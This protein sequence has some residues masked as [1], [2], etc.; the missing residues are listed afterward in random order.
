MSHLAYSAHKLPAHK[1]SAHK[2]SALKYSAL[3]TVAVVALAACSGPTPAPS[4]SP[5][6]DGTP[7]PSAPG[8]LTVV[9]HESFALPEELLAR[10]ADQTGLEVTYITPGEGTSLVNQLIL[11]KDSPLGDVVYGIDNGFAARAVDEGVLT[12]WTSP[13]STVESAF[14]GL[15]PIN[16]GDVC[17]N[18]DLTWFDEK[19]LALPETFEDLTDEAYRDLLVV[20]NPATSSPGMAMLA[21]TV[22]TF[23]EDGWLDYWQRL[24]DNG[25]RIAAGWTEAYYTDFS[26]GESEGDRPLV[27]SYSTSPAFTVVGDESTTTALLGTCFRQ[28]EYAG[29]LAGAANEAGAQAFVDFLLTEEVQAAIPESMYMYPIDESV[30]LPPEWE[31]FAPLS[32]N[33][34]EVDPAL[35]AAERDQWIRDF[36]E[37]I[38]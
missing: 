13:D 10:F 37:Q 17:V 16:R 19:G 29:V 7:S 9:T 27:L 14:E 1:R 3:A 36:S 30:A 38:R 4:G 33:P 25:M 5:T 6:G 2:R 21:A 24:S 22:G 31:A 23:G 18:A 8:E 20:P 35:I 34:V 12:P 26:G 15:T 28:T 11:T 32:D